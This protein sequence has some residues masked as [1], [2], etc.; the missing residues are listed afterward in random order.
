MDFK[1]NKHRRN[2]LQAVRQYFDFFLQILFIELQLPVNGDPS[3]LGQPMR[4][5]RRAPNS[6]RGRQKSQFSTTKE[7][8]EKLRPLHPFPGILLEWRRISGSLT[9][10]VFA[11]QK[12]KVYCENLGMHRIFTDVQYF[13]ATGR[14]S[15]SEPNLQNVPKDFL[16][17]VSGLY[18]K[19]L[20]TLS[21][22]C[23]VRTEHP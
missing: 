9:K 18:K 14:V 22:L 3:S 21:Y 17:S 5:N 4:P 10:V 8:L 16:I 15:L 1:I 23:Q 13:T 20:K 12:E 11:L 2:Q 6:H 19:S 7:V